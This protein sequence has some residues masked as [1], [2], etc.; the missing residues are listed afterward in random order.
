MQRG[1]ARIALLLAL[2][3]PSAVVAADLAYVG[4]SGA[5]AEPAVETVRAR[6]PG[7]DRSV[8][9]ATIGAVADAVRGGQAAGGMIPGMSVGGVPIETA[10]L[11]LG[12]LDPGVRIVGETHVGDIAGGVASFWLVGRVL[13]HMPDLHPDWLAVNIE[14]PGGSKAFSLVVAGLSK[15]GF[16][17]VD[18]ASVPLST[19]PF[20]FRYLLVLAADKPILALR[21]TDAIARDSRVGEGRALVIGAWKQGP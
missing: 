17:V 19:K 12:A 14:A 16:T 1:C 9:L 7:F 15:L 8:A 13:T 20:G 10:K 18:V 3:W 2:V 21:A 5:Q 4:E 6:L 11:L